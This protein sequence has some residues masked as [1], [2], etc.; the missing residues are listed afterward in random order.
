[1]KNSGKKIFFGKF[2]SLIL[3]H[4]PEVTGIS[5]DGHGWAEVDKVTAGI[6]RTRKPERVTGINQDK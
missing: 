6:G 4:R 1:M 3:R 2:L 5:P